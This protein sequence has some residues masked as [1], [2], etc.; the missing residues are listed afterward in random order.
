[1]EI[2]HNNE[3]GTVCDDSW[4]INDVRVVCRELGY[5]NAGG[6]AYSSAHFGQ[7]SGSIWL[8]NVH[9]AGVESSI[10]VCSHNGWDSHNCNHGEDAGVSCGT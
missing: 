5:S 10:E 4:D 7:G 9:C 3:W 1:M 2:F 8:D 6:T